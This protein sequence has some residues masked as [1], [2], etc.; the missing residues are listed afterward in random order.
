MARKNTQLVKKEDTVSLSNRLNEMFFDKLMTLQELRFFLVYVSKL[1]P[2]K[3]EQTEV[4]FTL[5]EYSEVL[6][7]ELNEASIG[8]ATD[9]L[10]RRIVSVRP[11]VL[12]EDEAEVIIKTQLF[13]RCKMTRRKSD[14][15]WLFTF[16]AS[17]DVKPHIFDL[18]EQFTSFEIWNIINLGN[19]QDARMYMLLRQ[20]RTIGQ[21]TIE[22]KALKKMLNIDPA[23]YPEYKIFARAVLK[24]C[25]KALKQNTDICFDFNAVGRPAT[26]VHFTITENKDYR[27]P[28][29]LEDAE[30]LEG[31]QALPEV[32]DVYDDHI[33]WLS[34]ACNDEFSMEEVRFLH[35]LA[36]ERFPGCDIEEYNYIRSKYNLLQS[37]SAKGKIRSSRYG[38]LKGAV[39]NDW[40]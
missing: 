8:R 31:Q 37:H 36:K 1:N 9:E 15:E 13:R 24:K 28:K 23:A 19:V 33:V 30:E 4:S 25:Q 20:Y 6:G 14:N 18:T 21:R 7:V 17:E 3:P 32:V 35:D 26:A 12:A 27:L 39:E 40:K 38:W 10:L 29:F 22:L 2:K 5:K 16:D 34:E 11:K